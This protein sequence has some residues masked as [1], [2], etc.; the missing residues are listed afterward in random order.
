MWLL[1]AA[2]AAFAP[3]CDCTPAHPAEHIVT[4]DVVFIGR[5]F[6]ALAGNVE[7]TVLKRFKGKPPA[8]LKVFDLA[9]AC[10]GAKPLSGREYLVM[11][12]RSAG[13]WVIGPCEGALEIENAS[14][15]L[16]YLR[17]AD[18]KRPSP[19]LV[20][21][22]IIFVGAART[23]ALVRLRRGGTIHYATADDAGLFAFEN[24]PEGEYKVETVA[25][26]FRAVK[27]P[28]IHV[29]RNGITRAYITMQPERAPRQ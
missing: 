25:R 8:R 11:A 12:R 20:T 1:A 22:Q 21:G 5:V 29:T 6:R 9:D 4:S 13:L 15:Y 18:L 24:I 19:N 10:G 27:T 16:S 26:G 3:S 14:R 2:F 7:Y 23:S 28:S 17:S